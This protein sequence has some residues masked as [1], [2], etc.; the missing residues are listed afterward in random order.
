[1]VTTASRA[2]LSSVLPS[3]V[4]ELR[5]PLQ[6]L[7]NSGRRIACGLYLIKLLITHPKAMEPPEK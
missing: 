5:A 1:M 2:V 3:K 4:I 7:F 6:Y